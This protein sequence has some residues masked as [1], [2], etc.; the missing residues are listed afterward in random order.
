VTVVGAKYTIKSQVER[1]E[2]RERKRKAVKR[3]PEFEKRLGT[4]MNGP[5]DRSIVM[6]AIKVKRG[7]TYRYR[8]LDKQ[9]GR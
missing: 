4:S 5:G 7:W 1:E 9:V 8:A 6:G 3:V 2:H